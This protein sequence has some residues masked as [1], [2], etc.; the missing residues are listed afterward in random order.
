LEFSDAQLRSQQHSL[1]CLNIMQGNDV[2][3]F[4]LLSSDVSGVCLTPFCPSLRIT[5]LL[6]CGGGSSQLALLSPVSH[7]PSPLEDES[8]Q[9]SAL[10]LGRRQAGVRR[11]RG[12]PAQPG[13]ANRLARSEIN[14][15]SWSSLRKIGSPSS[16]FSGVMGIH[17][18]V[19]TETYHGRPTR[20]PRSVPGSDAGA[21]HYCQHFPRS[22]SH[23]DVR[24]LKKLLILHE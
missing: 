16:S 8:G 15:R 9:A 23:E 2:F 17:H 19:H 12:P 20:S 22:P 13:K 21:L 24:R 3:F 4:S 11:C 10:L 14:G 7:V 6:V 18:A 1:D 5:L